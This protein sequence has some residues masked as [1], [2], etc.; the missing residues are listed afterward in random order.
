MVSR[1]Q[2][3]SLIG[4]GNPIVDISA[5]LEQNEL[6]KYNLDWGKTVFANDKN[7]GIY[8]CLEKKKDVSYIPGG[9]IQN[10]LRVICWCLKSSVN[11]NDLFK[12]TM[13]GCVGNDAY[14]DKIVTALKDIGV[15]PLL[16]INNKLP[17]SRCGVG[18]YKKE[19][20]LIPQIIASNTLSM[21]FVKKKINQI[22]DH[23][24]L[25][26]E[27]YFIKEKY[28]IVKYLVDE[29]KA[30]K[31][32]I[33]FALSAT[34]L[35][36]EENKT[37]DKMIKIANDS[38]YIFG[39]MEEAQALIEDNTLIFQDTFKKVHQMF[40]K[41]D[42]YLIITVGA[43]GVFASKYDYEKNNL[44]F[45]IQSF[46]PFIDNDDIVDLNGAGDAFLGGFLSQWL[47]GKTLDQCCKMGNKASNVIMR[48]IGCTYPKENDTSNKNFHSNPINNYYIP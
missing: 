12:I 24:T 31:K 36:Q 46:P 15:C 34:F 20:C 26:I 35:L 1:Q 40:T 30:K 8:D 6:T 32:T 3:K 21:E 48:N 17:S 18:I 42:R 16:Q 41:K 33:M 7:I 2:S 25:V 44:D 5:E 4:I 27:G 9:S 19:R 37:R 10:C 14:K 23:N 29:F 39:N 13:L 47:Q 11:N 45:I 28:D 43:Q 22:K 38:D